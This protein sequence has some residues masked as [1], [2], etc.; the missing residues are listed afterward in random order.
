MRGRRIVYGGCFFARV[1]GKSEFGDERGR[2]GCVGTIINTPH[3][4]G[5]APWAVRIREIR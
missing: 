3:Q 5:D 2:D 1:F 4:R